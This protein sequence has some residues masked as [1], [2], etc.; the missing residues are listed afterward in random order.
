MT[1]GGLWPIVDCEGRNGFDLG[2]NKGFTMFDFKLIRRPLK[3][4]IFANWTSGWDDGAHGRECRYT[5]DAEY[6]R[7]WNDGKPFCRIA[8]DE[9]TVVIVR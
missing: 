9:D 6:V 2:A 8:N 5:Q 3:V 7:G 1:C 4:L